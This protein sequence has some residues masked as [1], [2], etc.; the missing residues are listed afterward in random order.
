MINAPSDLHPPLYREVS[1]K[2]CI[3]VE[4]CTN[5]LAQSQTLLQ[6]SNDDQNLAAIKNCA[7][8]NSQ[9]HMWYGTDVVVEESCISEDGVV[10][11]GFDPCAWGQGRPWAPLSEER[12][13][14]RG[15]RERTR[16]IEC[17][18]TIL[19]DTS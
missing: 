16:F 17:Y 14:E 10:R 8:T 12:K 5:S 6:S 3:P 9:S 18:M 19:S 4:E 11:E 13:Y 7:N 2:W 15:V 1:V